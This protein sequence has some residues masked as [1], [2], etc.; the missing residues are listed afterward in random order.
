ML[1]E[2]VCFF[3]LRAG[4]VRRMC[5]ALPVVVPCR[6]ERGN[7]EAEA[8]MTFLAKIENEDERLCFV[9]IQEKTKK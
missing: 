3:G 5:S 1:G 8:H 6:V 4:W 9:S 2:K 7:R